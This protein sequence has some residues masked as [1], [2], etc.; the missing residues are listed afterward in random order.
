MTRTEPTEKAPNSTP[1]SAVVDVVIG[2]DTHVH[3]HSA[4]V[5]HAVT[6][7][8]LDQV[9]VAADGEGYAELVEFADRHAVLRAWAVEGTSSHGRGLCALLLERGE[10]VV[11][12]NRPVRAKRRNGV[13]SDPMDA[14]RAAREA[15]GRPRLGAPRAG[16][17]RQALANLQVARRSAVNGAGTAQRQLFSLVLVA[18]EPLRAR[19]CDL[20]TTQMVAAAAKLRHHDS[21]DTETR[22]TITAMKT[23]ARRITLL[24]QEATELEHDIDTVVKSWRPDLLA[25]PGIGPILAAVILCAWSHP[26]R[27]HSEAGFAMLGGVAPI[28]ANSGQTINRHRLNCYGDRRLN[29]ALHTIAIVRTRTDQRTRDYIERRTTEGKTPREIRRCLKRYIIRDLYRLLEAK[30]GVDAT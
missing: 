21:H 1:L 25:E 3:T 14:V 16:G 2:V 6:G 7:A 4:A 27:I 13:K 18:P 20:K 11:E 24:Q 10:E 8:V 5:V 28:P 17:D 23:L 12:L 19:F 15:L 30:P 9:T 29:R 26:G 22:Y